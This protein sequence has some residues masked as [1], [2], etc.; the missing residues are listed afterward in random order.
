MD[1]L[2][3][4]YDEELNSAGDVEIVGSTFQRSRILN[5][6]EKVTYDVAFQE[7]VELRRQSMLDRANQILS[8]YD[9]RNRFN[10][11][12]S[13]FR[14]PGVVP[15]I[16]A[17]M[18]MPS[19]YPGW[20]TFLWDMQ[21]ESHV[22]AD[23]LNNL[24]S[25]GEYESAAQLL[26][27]DLGPV[28]FNRQLQECYA[29]SKKILGAVHFLPLVFPSTNILT[30]N[31]DFVLED[32]FRNKDQGFDQV[33]FGNSLPE[34]LRLF[35][36]KTRML[37]KIHGTC[38]IVANR[39]LLRSEYER[40]YADAGSVKSFFSRF[41]FAKSLFFLGCSLT[42]DRT[43]KA[44]EEVVNEEGASTLPSHYAFLE[45]K[46]SQAR[47]TRKKMLAKANILPIWYPENEHDE[48]VEALL[49]ALM[50]D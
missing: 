46:A 14:G 31:F 26:Y 44:M 22:S 6:L 10:E 3:P 35:H 42:T 32:L 40:A 43:L 18:S 30:T 16:G 25:N 7:W 11:L 48:S 9:N 19:G 38:N 41:M 47:V 17:G 39:V 24:L 2:A 15:F 12:K 50:E 1:F 29:Q 45:L 4:L 8:M 23:D 27:D 13:A 36:I 49:I 34:V 28:L 5:E 33:I 20:T 37:V 21:A